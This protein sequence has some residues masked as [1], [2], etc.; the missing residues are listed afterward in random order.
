MTKVKQDQSNCCLT[1]IHC[2]TDFMAN[3]KLKTDLFSESKC[4]VGSRYFIVGGKIAGCQ[5]I[6]TGAKVVNH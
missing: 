6:L 4:I 3:L 5:Y 1:S 2:A